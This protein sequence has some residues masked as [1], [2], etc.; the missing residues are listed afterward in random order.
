MPRRRA[1]AVDERHVHESDDR[2]VHRHV[3]ANLRRPIG[4]LRALRRRSSCGHETEHENTARGAAGSA[5]AQLLRPRDRAREHR[6]LPRERRAFPS[7]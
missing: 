5:S 6:T 7:D 3:P 2:G 1:A 4:A